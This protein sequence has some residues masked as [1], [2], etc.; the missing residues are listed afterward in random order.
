MHLLRQAGG[1]LAV[2]QSDS[3]QVHRKTGGGHRRTGR[4]AQ[5]QQSAIIGARANESA[6]RGFQ[7]VDSRGSTVNGDHARNVRNRDGQADCNGQAKT[8]QGFHLHPASAQGTG[9]Q[10]AFKAFAERNQPDI[11]NGGLWHDLSVIPGDQLLFQCFV[12]CP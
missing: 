11:V 8:G 1:D 2:E 4:Q 12:L 3:D 5:Q 6:R 10:S 9:I 7:Q